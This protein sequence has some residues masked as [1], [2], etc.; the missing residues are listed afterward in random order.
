MH[1]AIKNNIHVVGQGEQVIIFAHGFGCDQNMWK[2]ILPDFLDD[3]R[4]ILFDYTG[5]G[6]SNISEYDPKK[7]STL[8]GYAQDIL[9]I[10]EAYQL[11]DVIIVGHSVSATI[12][13]LASLKSPQYFSRLIHLSPSPSFLNDPPEY[14]GGFERADLEE[15]LDLMDKNYIGWASYLAPLVIGGQASELMTGELADSFCSTDPLIAQNFAKATF[16][17]D[18][19]ESYKLSTLPSLIIQSSLDTLASSHV[20]SYLHRITPRSE[21]TI[22][23]SEG[24]C[25]HMTHPTLTSQAIKF[26]LS[27]G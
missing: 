4:V 1:P 2:L 12:A 20:G 13:T 11:E 18:Y 5:S 21:L 27:N 7:Y 25:P 22:I 6:R 24:H 3:Y 19:R 23:N 15:L 14:L 16:L 26:Y 17:S 8:E 9:D 10:C